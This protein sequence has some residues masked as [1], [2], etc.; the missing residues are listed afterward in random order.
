MEPD[1]MRR[2]PR[3]RNE[4]FFADNLGPRI[5]IR[6][7][8]LGWLSWYIFD[9][10]LD[11][12]F[13]LGYAETMAFAT[14]IFAQLWHI[15]DARSFSTIYQKNPFNNGYLLLAILTSALLSLAVIYTPFGNLA[16]G[17]EPLSLRHLFMIIFIA[18]LPTFA[19]SG[20]K[21][22]FRIKYL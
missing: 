21:A 10:A 1:L 6:G 18:A 5:V 22:I 20:I 9:R 14:L 11:R 8:V 12:G 15:F 7:L 13:D 16:L 19:L 3:P 4:D 2:R 17:T